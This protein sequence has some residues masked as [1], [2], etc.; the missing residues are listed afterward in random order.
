MQV[1][2]WLLLRR[3]VLDGDAAV[4]ARQKTYRV[5]KRRRL[6]PRSPRGPR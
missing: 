2:L 1:R 4:P 5:M 6:P 3:E